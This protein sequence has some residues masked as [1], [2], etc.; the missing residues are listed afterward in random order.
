MCQTLEKIKNTLWLNITSVRSENVFTVWLNYTLYILYFS[1]RTLLKINC[2]IISK[3]QKR[4]DLLQ[5]GSCSAELKK[6]CRRKGWRD[7]KKATRVL[8]HP[9]KMEQGLSLST[10]LTN[11]YAPHTLYAQ[12]C[13]TDAA[14]GSELLLKATDARNTE[15]HIESRTARSQSHRHSP[16]FSYPGL[17]PAHTHVSLLLSPI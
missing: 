9:D 6:R 17:N 11:T 7:K 13:L 15:S 2:E 14:P 4:P 16:Q 8:T 3:Y 1:Y 10:S 12:A 5:L